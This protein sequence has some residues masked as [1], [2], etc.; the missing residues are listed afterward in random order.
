MVSRINDSF[1]S[2]RINDMI[3]KTIPALYHQLVTTGRWKA[4]TLK[5][6]EVE[7]VN[8]LWDSDVAKFAESVCYAFS[9][10]P[11]ADPRRTHFAS[12][13]DEIMDM[14]EGSQWPDGYF[15]SH[16]TV[17]APERRFTNLLFNHEMYNLG[18]FIEAAVAYYNA[19]GSW[20]FV[21]LCDKYINC[22]ID[23]FGTEEGKKQGYPGHEEIELALLRLYAIRPDEKY[24][25]FA[26]YLVDERGGHNGRYFHDEIS[27]RGHNPATWVPGWKYSPWTE[28]EQYW[29]MQAHK[30]VREQTEI[31]GHSVRAMYFLTA[32]ERLAGLNEDISLS[33]A[34]RVLWRNMVDKKLYIHGGIGAIHRFEGFGK[35]FELPLDGYSETCASLGIL[36]LAK[37]MLSNELNGEYG[38]IMERALYNDC[39]GGV[40]FDGKLFFYDQPLRTTEFKRHEWFDV[41]CCPANLCRVL[42]SLTEYQFIWSKDI[43]AVVFYIGSIYKKEGLEVEVQSNYPKKGK[44]TL[45]IFSEYPTQV[46]VRAP[47]E[48]YNTSVP[49][50]EKNGFI[51]LE[52]KKYLG[53]EISITWKITPKVVI[54]NP[55]VEAT[56]GMLAVERGPFVYAL[57]EIDTPGDF[58]K[59]KLPVNA[60]FAEKEA[61]F[62]GKSV[63]ALETYSNN[64]PIML[65]PYYSCGNRGQGRGMTVWLDAEQPSIESEVAHRS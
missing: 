12:W 15:N 22:L 21:D 64:G 1:W 35:D 18:H 32:V 51:Y 19:F 52:K 20:R 33:N 14:I 65:V 17:E 55:Y 27:A 16:Y 54:P 56:K 37:Q 30:P 23:H 60:N 43:L 39:I 26:T 9:I 36:F 10:L 4:L 62:G 46:A 59:V 58:S 44:V 50:E 47:S 28:P 13:L 7:K 38:H 2:Q 57:E 24:L 42:L 53:E 49:V 61:S 25:S 45:K 48:P 6:H 11:D 5:T 34:V 31:V 8:I 41:S 3:E 63:I 29:Y 40:S